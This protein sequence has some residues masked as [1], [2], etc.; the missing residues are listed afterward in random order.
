M[1]Q[2]DLE[3]PITPR[4]LGTFPPLSSSPG[5]PSPQLWFLCI[6]LSRERGKLP[7]PPWFLENLSPNKGEDVVTAGAATSPCWGDECKA[8]WEISYLF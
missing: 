8:G 2:C 1:P 4:G 7:F 5:L 3:F 6:L